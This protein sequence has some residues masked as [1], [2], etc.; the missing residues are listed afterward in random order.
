MS[1][2]NSTF[3]LLYDASLL[4]P[5]TWEETSPPPGNKTLLQA[6]VTAG[7]LATSFKQAGQ[8]QLQG[9]PSHLQ[10]SAA[11]PKPALPLPAHYR[12]FA[13]CRVLHALGPSAQAL[14]GSPALALARP[15][16]TNTCEPLLNAAQ[17]KGA[18][19][20]IPYAYNTGGRSGPVQR[21]CPAVLAWRPPPHALAWLNASL[22]PPLHSRTLPLF[23]VF[24]WHTAGLLGSEQALA[25][26]GS[27]CCRCAVVP[28]LRPRHIRS[29]A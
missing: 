22:N 7:D 3:A 26:A 6:T 15:L 5:Q 2:A 8:G 29:P 10:R 18:V 13:A 23:D 4:L 28:N 19:L 27:R 11:T 17:V 1:D 9:R 20:L 12:P 16:P 25:C 14:V 21:S 24:R